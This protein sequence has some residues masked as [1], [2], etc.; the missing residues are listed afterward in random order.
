MT[1]PF[2]VWRPGDQAVSSADIESRCSLVFT[3][4][5][6]LEAHGLGIPHDNGGISFLAE[7]GYTGEPIL[8]TQAPGNPGWN[9][10]GQA[11][12][13]VVQRSNGIDALGPFLDQIER[14][15]DP[16]P[17]IEYRRNVIRKL[18]YRPAGGSG[19]AIVR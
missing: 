15:I 9:P 3:R 11:I 1:V 17:G 16:D 2:V 19:A 18:F 8:L 6:A 12:C 10:V 13:E 5:L 7:F 14:G 4:S